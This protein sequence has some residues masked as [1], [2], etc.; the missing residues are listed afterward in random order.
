MKRDLKGVGELERKSGESLQC[1]HYFK[2]ISHIYDVPR[3]Q[4]SIFFFNYITVK[5]HL[6][7]IS[8]YS[9]MKEEL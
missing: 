2:I 6:I 4:A 5:S 1:A 9:K 8:G 3:L 7:T